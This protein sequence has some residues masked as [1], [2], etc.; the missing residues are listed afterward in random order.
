VESHRAHQRRINA[1]RPISNGCVERLQ[2]TILEEELPPAWSA[3]LLLLCDE[4]GYIPFDPR[5]QP[6]VR[7]PSLR[8]RDP[9]HPTR[10]SPPKHRKRT[11]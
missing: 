2:L 11:R 7:Q 9:D 1:G 6:D 8:V 10:A 4:V 3:D 5:R